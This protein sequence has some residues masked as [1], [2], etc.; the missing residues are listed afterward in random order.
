MDDAHDDAKRTKLVSEWMTQRVFYFPRCLRSETRRD[1]HRSFQG[2][3]GLFSES[4]TWAGL[5]T[6]TGRLCAAQYPS[7]G[8]IEGSFADNLNRDK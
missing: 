2:A 4:G 1:K 3:K 8:S 6:A 7:F 5:R